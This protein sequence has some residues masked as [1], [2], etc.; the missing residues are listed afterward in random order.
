MKITTSL[1]VA[2][3]QAVG[4]T[5]KEL[6]AAGFNAV[7]T[8]E[9]AHDPFMPLAVAATTTDTLELKTS[10]AIAFARSPM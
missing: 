1:P 5:A 10:V 8:Q 2:D 6:E 4:S 3:L 9:S 7:S